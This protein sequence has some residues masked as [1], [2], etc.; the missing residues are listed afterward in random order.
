MKTLGLA[1]LIALL[2]AAPAWPADDDAQVAL[3]GRVIYLDVNDGIVI[4]SFPTGQRVINMD[5]RELQRYILGDEI[6]LD[7]LGRPL[8][9][10][11]R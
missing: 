4:G 3:V 2:S 5:R 6:R 9:P 7:S 8:P 10:R 11:G 1:L